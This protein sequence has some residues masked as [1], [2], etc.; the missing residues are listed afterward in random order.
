MNRSYSKIRHIQESNLV[1]ENRRLEE[2]SKHLLMEDSMRNLL[3]LTI[4][5]P[6][7]KDP[8]TG[9]VTMLS[10]GTAKYLVTA[11]KSPDDPTGKSFTTDDYAGI[12]GLFING[13]SA[14]QVLSKKDTTTKNISGTFTVTEPIYKYLKDFVGKGAQNSQDV[15]GNV[16]LSSGGSEVKYATW[17]VT[18]YDATPTQK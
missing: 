10:V 9:K 15:Y 5:L 3:P 12:K 8:K 7:K 16:T 14:T 6:T 1:L 2:K 13:I 4:Y 11:T 18:T 17:S